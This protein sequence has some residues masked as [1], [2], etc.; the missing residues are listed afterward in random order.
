MGADSVSAARVLHFIPSFGPGGAERQLVLVAAELARMGVEVHVAFV[1]GGPNL[2]RLENA[3]VRLHAL[4]AAGNHDP[5]LAWRIFRLVQV[6]RPDVIQTWLT[7]M[8]ILAGAAAILC[9]V[10]LIVSE[11]CN[12]PAYP[13]GWKTRLRRM[14]GLRADRV[15]A[16]SRAGLDYWRPDVP[17]ERL[18]LIR[19]CVSPPGSADGA[20]PDTLVARTEGRPLVM[21][22]GRLA[23]QKNV[24]TLVEALTIVALRHPEAVMVLFG[25]GPDRDDIARRIGAAGMA[26]RILLAGYS[27]CLSAW[28]ERAAVFV[29]VSHFEG[30]PN[31][32]I[33]AASV[34][35]PLVISDIPPHRELF[36]VDSAVFVP[37][38]TPTVIADAVLDI[39]AHPDTARERASRARATTAH[40]TLTAA[41]AAYRSVYESLVTRDARPME[42]SS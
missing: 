11:R 37:V 10:P 31:V 27:S 32:V 30:H 34:G 4:D 12:A 42:R 25:E 38:D 8:D 13:R 3:S 16:N 39:L 23:A 41:A 26:D 1:A 20:S 5:M 7:Q 21:F 2:A 35:C 22:A 6:V 24:P 36:D 15:I 17:E 18:A 14:I 19:N 40:W 9:R 33:E 29:S 28:M